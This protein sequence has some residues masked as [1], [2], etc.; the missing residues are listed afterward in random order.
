MDN[1]LSFEASIDLNHP[2]NRVWQVITDP[3]LVKE[4]FF[5]TLVKSDWQPGSPITFTG[6]WEGKAYQDKGTILKVEPEK[7]LRFNYWSNFS[8]T[9][10]K[11]E[12]YSIITYRLAPNGQ[13][14]KLTIR[15]EGFESEEKR[16]H[17]KQNWQTVLEGMRE[18][19]DSKA[20]G[21]PN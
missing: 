20:N 4:Y 15:Q 17:S 1:K 6:S 2:A 21:S 19:L 3:E 13:A 18:L 7:L 8:G 14:T 10:D 5:G 16:D 9:E 12:N 11:A